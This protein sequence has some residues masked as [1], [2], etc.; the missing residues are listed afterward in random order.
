MNSNISQRFTLE[1]QVVAITGGAGL[2]GEMHAQAILEAKG[3]PVILDINQERIDTISNRLTE[4]YGCKILGI[5][6]DITSA[7]SINNALELILNEHGRLDGLVNNA[8]NDPKVSGNG[9]SERLARFENMSLDF[10]NKDIAVGLTG[11]FLC[12]QVF[13]S[14]MAKQNRGVI[15]NFASDLA[16]IAPDQRL[17]RKA[18]LAEDSQPVKPVTYSVVKTAMLGLTRYLSTYWADKNIRVNSISPGGV[19]NGQNE[20]FLNEVTSRIPMARMAFKD[21]YKS[22][23]VFLLSDAS[24]YMTGANIV[25]DGGRSVW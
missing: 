10:W 13:G 3:N 25:I 20:N 4:E 5:R 24:S 17:Y 22:A 6:C 1:N 16:V 7:E 8:A 12:C 21:E 15:L 18:G 2:L 19:Y 23:V 14:Y 11:S 9:E